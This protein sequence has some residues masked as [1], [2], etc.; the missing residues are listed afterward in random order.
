LEDCGNPISRVSCEKWG[1]YALV[2]GTIDLRHLWQEFAPLWTPIAFSSEY[3]TNYWYSVWSNLNYI[4][5]T[6]RKITVEIPQHLLEKAQQ[7]S[8][9]GITQTVRT[10]CSWWRR[11]KRKNA[12]G[13]CEAKFA[14]LA[15]RQS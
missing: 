11:R 14:S 10:G 6:A 1:F 15:L 13:V 12:S 4:V 9:T 8:G 7:A 2:L 5:D 3:H